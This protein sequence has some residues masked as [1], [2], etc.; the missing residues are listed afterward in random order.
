MGGSAPKV[1]LAL[2]P[3]PKGTLSAKVLSDYTPNS[4]VI[5]APLLHLKPILDPLWKKIAR[6]TQVPGGESASNTWSFYGACKNLGA[7]H[8]LGAEI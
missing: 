6:G 4:K 8:P 1:V 2:T 7:Q 3:Q 5:S